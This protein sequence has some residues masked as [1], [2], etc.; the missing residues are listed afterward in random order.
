MTRVQNKD[1]RYL[2]HNRKQSGGGEASMSQAHLGSD[3]MKNAFRRRGRGGGEGI[4]SDNI[5]SNLHCFCTRVAQCSPRFYV[6]TGF[7]VSG[8]RFDH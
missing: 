6:I 8:K 1:A 2:S 3:V 7:P 5:I 4:L